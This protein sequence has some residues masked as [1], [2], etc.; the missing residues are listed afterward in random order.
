MKVSGLFVSVLESTQ[1]LASESRSLWLFADAVEMQRR[2]YMI[3][4]AE[5]TQD[6]WFRLRQ[7]WIRLLQCGW[8]RQLRAV[9]IEQHQPSITIEKGM[10]GMFSQLL[11]ARKRMIFVLL[12][13]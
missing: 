2:H 3:F 1:Y 13:S 12:I 6:H 4:V 5:S 7:R 9:E 8:M 11:V 10:N